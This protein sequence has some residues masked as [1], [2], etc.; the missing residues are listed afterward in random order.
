MLVLIN[1]C[2]ALLNV[3]ANGAKKSDFA[4]GKQPP[5]NFQMLT[6]KTMGCL[7]AGFRSY[8][9]RGVIKNF[10]VRGERVPLRGRATY[11]L[12]EVWHCSAPEVAKFVESI[13]APVQ[14][15]RIRDMGRP[16]RPP[17]PD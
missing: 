1:F 3:C 2:Y 15:N 4:H 9:F 5:G 12:V 17:P 14:Q 10:K 7:C 13:R 11:G 16:R 8:Q 6:G